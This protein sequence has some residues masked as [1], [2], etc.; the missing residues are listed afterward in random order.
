MKARDTGVALA[1]RIEA[2]GMNLSAK[3][4]QRRC[5]LIANRSTAVR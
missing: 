1:D 2:A 4:Q 5:A 3:S